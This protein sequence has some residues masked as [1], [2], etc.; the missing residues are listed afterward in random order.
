[1]HEPDSPDRGATDAAEAPAYTGPADHLG[2]CLDG[3]YLLVKRHVARFG[4][5]ML[6]ADGRLSDLYVGFGE[7]RE[8]AR[9]GRGTTAVPST[10][11]YDGWPTTADAEADL[12]SH[13]DRM[14]ARLE[15][16]SGGDAH[17][18]VEDLRGAYQ[19]SDAQVRLV[20]A[21]AAPLLSVDL[22]RFYTFAWADFAVKVPTVGFLAE[23]AA[24]APGDAAALADELKG[25]GLLVRSRLVALRDVKSWGTPTPHL[26]RG[27]TVPEGVLAF[28]QGIRPGTS[29]DAPGRW[30]PADAALPTDRLVLPDE[31]RRDL[32]RTL[33]LA[34]H[35]GRGRPRILLDGPAGSGRRTALSSLLA[36][37]GFG[38]LEVDL[39][40]LVRDETRFEDRLGDA[41]REALLH[42]SAVLL[43]CDEALATRDDVVR[44]GPALGRIV[45]G[46]PG[47]VAL[48]TRQGA[49]LL[50]AHIEDLFV[51]PIALPAAE[52]QRDLW[53]RALE[54]VSVRPEPNAIDEVVRRFTL[55]PGTIWR[56]A[57]DAT[58]ATGV[59]RNGRRETPVSSESLRR[60]ILRHIDH[61]LGVLAD[62]VRTT[63]GWK[64]VVLPQEVRDLLREILSCARN[65]EQVMDRWGFRQKMSYGRGLSCLFAGPPGTGKTMMA[66]ILAADLGREAYRIDL[67]RVVSKWVG[68]TE[69]NLAR[70]FDEAERA[71]AILL[72]DEADSLFSQRTGVQ[73]SN[74]RFANMEVNYLLQRMEAYEGITILTTNFEQSIDEAFKRRLKFR[75]HFPLPDAGER[76][77]LWAS[78]IPPEAPVEGDIDFEELGSLF[79]IAGG[80]IKNAVLRAA[81]LAVDEGRGISSD[82][83]TRAATAEAREMGIL[84]RGGSG[85]F[86]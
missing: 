29:A 78:M 64:D 12:R 26:H 52:T 58:T 34:A 81:Y 33:G 69:K 79:E 54:E 18:P 30:W 71:Q 57:Q 27:V 77:K 6:Q 84:V 25:D 11:R 4:Y 40:D 51:C 53:A 1:M 82:H 65:R 14:A 19:L 74:D 7:A 13:Q 31:T 42:Q 24:D 9:R 86:G 63:L 68:E 5:R 44:H 50:H 23:L 72:F 43:R 21:A 47:I 20:L 49:A 35:A 17:L 73:S 46:H 37:L 60:S 3:V 75:V 55:T 32:G 45:N 56:A 48:S 2:D 59:A 39:K 83:L 67:S 80:S 22:A 62:P 36:R 61:D 16:S 85:G 41:C 70:I 28:L 10:S 76:A 38:V 15:A 66:G 8:L